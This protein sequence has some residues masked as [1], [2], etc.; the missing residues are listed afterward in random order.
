[1][2]SFPDIGPASVHPP[3]AGFPF[4]KIPFLKKERKSGKIKER[5]VKRGISMKLPP[6]VEAVLCALEQAGHPAYLVGGCVRDMLL[7]RPCH[8]Y[9]IATAARPEQ[10]H[11]VL[12]R[13][14]VLDTGLAHG[15]VT[16]LLPETAV[17]ITTFRRESAYA[18]HRRPT[19]V[20]FSATLSQDLSR[21]DFTVNA[22]AM[23][24]RGRLFDPYHGRQDLSN[25]ILRCVGDPRERFSEDALR[26]LRAIRFAAVLRFSPEEN[27]ARC[28]KELCPLL[29]YVSRE[30]ILSE[31][32]LLLCAPGTAAVLKEF[33]L[34]L[35][36]ALPLPPSILQKAAA[37]I[38]RLPQN[39][40]LRL[41]FLFYLAG[42]GTEQARKILGALRTSRQLRDNVCA[43]LGALPLPPCRTVCDTRRLLCRF[44]PDVLQDALLISQ[45]ARSV[46]IPPAAD[47]VLLTRFKEEILRRGDCCRLADL[48]ITGRDLVALGLQGPAI[49]STL[50]ALLDAVI[51]GRLK[52]DRDALCRAALLLHPPK[53]RSA[54]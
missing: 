38:D 45:A 17:E 23:D 54:P 26:I 53:D 43:R 10:V 21:R 29:K 40:C 14:P 39:F 33:A 18:D 36:K 4:I 27:T 52:N 42:L 13:Y 49:G 35:S 1:M 37:G 11:A 9:D 20:S 48:N 22:M 50:R 19:S 51:D 3:D 47:L 28:L 2:V 8:D 32:H 7:G 12:N 30:R 44:G 46:G 6:S 16:V 34:P 15:T 24:R 25:G 5:Q 31:L 41:S